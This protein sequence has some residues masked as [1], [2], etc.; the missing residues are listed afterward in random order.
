MARKKG[1]GR[2]RK[3]A[4]KGDASGSVANSSGGKPQSEDA[5]RVRTIADLQGIL[6]WQLR[7]TST[8]HTPE[9]NRLSEVITPIVNS[10]DGVHRSVVQNTGN[11]TWASL[12]P[13]NGHD[14]TN[15]EN[16]ENSGS[17][18]DVNVKITF[19]DIQLEVEYWTNVVLCRVL[20]ST[21]PLQVMEGFFR[22]IW[23]RLGIDKIA[24]VA[25]G[26]YIV[27]F[28]SFESRSQVIDEGCLMFDKNPVIVQPWASD[29]NV[30]DTDVSRVP[31]WVPLLDLELKYWGQN[32]LMKLASTL[33]KPIKTDRVTAMKEL[34]SYASVMVEMSMEEEFPE[35]VSFEN[36]SGVICHVML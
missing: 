20:G 4:N 3:S 30:K 18:K 21:P 35:C 27:R 15:T 14:L 32:T 13:V 33:R 24:M 2:P 8:A 29:L 6:P 28:N 1:R 9:Q 36:D 16:G 7:S 11:R 5:R 25:K 17:S 12:F 26:I 23:G 34:L 19:K 10:D 22:R 31:V